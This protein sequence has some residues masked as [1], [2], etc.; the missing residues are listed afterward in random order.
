M[1]GSPCFLEVQ[2]S[3]QEGILKKYFNSNREMIMYDYGDENAMKSGQTAF[4]ILY[5][6]HQLDT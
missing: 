4:Y 2:N 3:L 1:I 5:H 6:S